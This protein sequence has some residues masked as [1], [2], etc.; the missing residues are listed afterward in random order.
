MMFDL[1]PKYFNHSTGTSGLRGSRLAIS[2][3]IFLY[4]L[5]K[6]VYGEGLLFFSSNLS[7]MVR[8]VCVKV[9][10]C[11]LNKFPSC[12]LLMFINMGSALESHPSIV[13]LDAMLSSI[14]FRMESIAVRTQL[15]K[16]VHLYVS[17]ISEKRHAFFKNVSVG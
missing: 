14:F 1:T 4:S 17:F 2:L 8:T 6:V 11:G 9:I 15:S 12:C 5:E 7:H 3:I 10:R 13:L 16:M